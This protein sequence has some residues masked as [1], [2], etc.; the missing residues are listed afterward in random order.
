MTTPGM[1]D[2]GAQLIAAVCRAAHGEPPWPDLSEA[3]RKEHRAEARAALARAT[4][5]TTED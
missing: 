2:A 4:T 1:V 3:R 5:T